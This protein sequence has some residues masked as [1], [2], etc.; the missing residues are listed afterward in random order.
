MQG[1]ERPLSHPQRAN[2]ALVSV[3]VCFFP[4]VVSVHLREREIKPEASM[5]SLIWCRDFEDRPGGAGASSGFLL[6]YLK[7]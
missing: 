1:F 7:K 2:R 5:V 3:G 4:G 6:F